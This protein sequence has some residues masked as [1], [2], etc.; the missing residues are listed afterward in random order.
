VTKIVAML[1]TQLGSRATA[2]AF[3]RPTSVP[4]PQSN[5]P[6][7]RVFGLTSD[8]VIEAED[9]RDLRWGVVACGSGGMSAQLFGIC[10]YT[11]A[12]IETRWNDDAADGLMMTQRAGDETSVETC[13]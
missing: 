13:A 3:A 11:L 9:E 1:H 6:P 12:S 4:R 10:F 7:W 8:G 2:S 5:P